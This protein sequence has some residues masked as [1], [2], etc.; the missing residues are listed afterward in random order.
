MMCGYGVYRQLDV[1]HAKLQSA[2]VGAHRRLCTGH[3]TV[4]QRGR[5]TLLLH[6]RHERLQRFGLAASLTEL[7]AA[8]AQVVAVVVDDDVAG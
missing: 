1:V 5:P 6:V 8:P 3:R 4:D 2:H 7:A